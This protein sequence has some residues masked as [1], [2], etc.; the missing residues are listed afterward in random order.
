MEELEQQKSPRPLEAELNEPLWWM[1]GRPQCSWKGGQERLD[2]RGV[3]QN[4]NRNKQANKEN[5]IC[6]ALKAADVPC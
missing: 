2:P 3:R 5:A 1:F 6:V 4:E